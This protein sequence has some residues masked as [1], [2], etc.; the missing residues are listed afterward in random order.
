MVFYQHMQGSQQPSTLSLDELFAW[1]IR[2]QVL[3]ENQEEHDL[4]SAYQ[5]MFGREIQID[6]FSDW[7]KVH[8]PQE[9]NIGGSTFMHAGG[10][11]LPITF[12]TFNHINMG[13]YT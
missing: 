3:V 12:T 2:F 11:I 10:S 5:M 4:L 9:V 1:N 6:V 13:V 7:V 8:G